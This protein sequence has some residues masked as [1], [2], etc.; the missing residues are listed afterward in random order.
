ML[1]LG[2]PAKALFVGHYTLYGPNG[3]ISGLDK[4]DVQALA[5][6]LLVTWPHAQCSESK[7]RPFSQFWRIAIWSKLELA[8][9]E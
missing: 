5:D 1:D 3:E 2:H 4:T 7:Q 8:G 6:K 9:N